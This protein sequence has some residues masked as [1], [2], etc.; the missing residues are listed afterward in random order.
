[1]FQDI[2]D[3]VT[4]LARYWKSTVPID[5]HVPDPKVIFVDHVGSDDQADKMLDELAAEAN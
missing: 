1:L 5:T 2:T 3:A 4:A